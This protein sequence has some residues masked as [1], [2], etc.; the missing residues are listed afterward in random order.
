MS[1]SGLELAGPFGGVAGHMGFGCCRLH[2]SL[3]FNQYVRAGCLKAHE[4]YSL[5]NLLEKEAPPDQ[6]S[7][8]SSPEDSWVQRPERTSRP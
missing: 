3:Q 2:L 6:V 1:M 7:K 4:A 5:R 8:K